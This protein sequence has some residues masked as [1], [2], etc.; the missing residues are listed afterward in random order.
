MT[1]DDIQRARSELM[2]VYPGCQIK[3]AEDKREVVAEISNGFAV[4][5]IEKTCRTFTSKRARS[6]VCY[7][8]GFM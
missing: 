4:A 5:V 8:A 7:V 3:V 2:D 6:T 1:N